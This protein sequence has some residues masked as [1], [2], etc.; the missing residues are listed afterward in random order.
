MQIVFK[1]TVGMKCHIL[2]SRK[3]KKNIVSLSSAEFAHGMVSVIMKIL[4]H[5]PWFL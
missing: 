1:D 5:L 3:S 4:S 2:F